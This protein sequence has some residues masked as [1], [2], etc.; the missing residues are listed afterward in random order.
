MKGVKEKRVQW[1]SADQ[2]SIYR[3]FFKF[4]GYFWIFI[5]SHLYTEESCLEW[6]AEMN[7]RWLALTEE[8][9]KA[10]SY[11]SQ[12]STSA[13]DWKFCEDLLKSKHILN[14]LKKKTKNFRQ[15]TFNCP[16]NYVSFFS[17]VWEHQNQMR[18][19][20]EVCYLILVKFNCGNTAH[21]MNPGNPLMGIAKKYYY[22]GF[23]FL[24]YTRKGGK[25]KY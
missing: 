1:S 2:V 20:F 23:F 3:K 15:G 22:S 21:L 7:M 9:Y 16:L 6:P 19:K 10:F 24:Q 8:F 5:W 18:I 17:R 14:S 25:W 12:Q 13:P 11:I 4:Q